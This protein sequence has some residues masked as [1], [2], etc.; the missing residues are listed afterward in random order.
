MRQERTIEGNFLLGAKRKDIFQWKFD[1]S[2]RITDSRVEGDT[3]Y[4]L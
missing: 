3:Y 2:M 4:I 1:V